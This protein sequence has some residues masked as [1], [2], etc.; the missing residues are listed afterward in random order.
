MSLSPPVKVF[1]LTVSMRCFFCGSFLLLVFH[2]C[3]VFLSLQCSLVIT[4]WERAGL[5]ALLCVMVSFVFCYI[6]MWCPGS[7]VLLD[8]IDA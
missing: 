6:P 3:R 5:L 2:V 8:C 7:G 1:I 4:C